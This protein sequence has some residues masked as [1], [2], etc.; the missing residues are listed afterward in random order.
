VLAFRFR[1]AAEELIAC[2]RVANVFVDRMAPWALRKTDPA[3]SASV[4]NTC[5]QWL[6]WLA[7]W[8]A[9]FLPGRAQAL[10]TM[11]GQ[12]GPVEREPWPGL[13]R[14]GTP[15]RS[16]AADQRLGEVGPLFAKLED[17][18][19]QSEIAALQARSQR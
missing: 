12:P 13:P 19:V 10:W 7:R 18:V 6:A 11:L 16:L 14:A 9:P 3:L 15:W 2:A 1:K 5:C 4:L 8:M 17:A